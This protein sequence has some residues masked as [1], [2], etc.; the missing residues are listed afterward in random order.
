M[1]N[2]G[3]TDTLVDYVTRTKFNDLPNEVVSMAKM[4]ILDSLG[5]ALGGY[6]TKIGST[7]IAGF[8]VTNRIDGESTVIGH[9]GKSLCRDAA[10]VNATLI[11]ALDYDDVTSHGHPASSILGGALAVAEK[12]GASG[13]GLLTSFVVGYEV[14]MR[15]GNSMRPSE[16]RWKKVW[17]V[18]SHQAFGPASAVSK[19]LGL[20]RI[21][22]LNAFGVAGTGSPIPSAQ[23]FGYDNRPCTFVKDAVGWAASAGTTGALLAHAGFLGCRDF[24]DGDMGF[25]IMAGPDRCDF[26][27]M[28]AGL[29]REY[30]IM[31]S[32]FKPYSACR[33]THATLDAVG[34][35]IKRHNLKAEDVK[36]VLV[37]S[38]WD[39]TELFVDYKPHEIVDAQFSMPYTVAMVFLGGPPGPNWFYEETLR[40]P[41][42]LDLARKVKVET[43]PR[44]QEEYHKP[45]PKLM[46]TVIITTKDDRKLE[47]VTL[48]GMTKGEPANPLTP[49]EL[50]EKFRRLAAFVLKKEQVETILRTVKNLEKIDHISE[51][52]RHLHARK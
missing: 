2:M 38:I 30:E 39:I 18:G 35:L 36:E 11:N 8:G 46:S 48:P 32:G 9:G 19:L 21:Q 41:K 17:G 44:A 20:N 28:T 43:D 6:K 51:L 22:T 26:N 37:R 14:D 5:C 49:H 7:V 23:K 10:Y 15:V 50:E 33:F 27:K 13:K 1:G 31:K 24:L 16:E 42:V 29:G 40:D 52:T 3:V 47:A 25:W 12:V 4:R 45:E 34:S